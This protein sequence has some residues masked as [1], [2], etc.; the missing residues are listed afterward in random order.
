MKKY[1]SPFFA[2]LFVLFSLNASADFNGPALPSQAGNSG[3]FL[4]TD[5]SLAS[6]AINAGGDVTG[7]ASATSTAIARFNGTTGKII[8]NS[9]ATIDGSGNLTATNFSG[10]STGTNTGD[11]II[12]LTGDVTGSGTGSFAAT[13][14]T[15]NSNVGTF[16]SATKTVTVTATG[17]GLITAISEQTAT[18]AVGSITGLGTGVAT[19]LATPSSANLASA[20]TDETGTGPLVFGTNPALTTATL[21]SSTA[22]TQTPADNS[23]KVA[24][25]AYVDNAVLGQRQ[26]EAVKYAS[27]AALPS[28]VYANGS[29]GVGR[30]LTGVA[31]AAI[32]LDSSSPSV[33]DRV[34]IKDQ[35][36]TFQNGIYT[37]TATGSGIAVFVLTGATDF[38]Q[39]SDIQTGDTTFVTAGS[40]LANTTW[41][42]NGI[43]SPTMGTTAITFAQAAGPGSFTGGNGITITGTSIAINTAVT[44][45]KTTAQ[46][47]TN[48]DLSGAGNTFPTFNQNTTGSAATLTTARTIGGVSFDGS[49][50][51]TVATATGGFTVSGGNL[52]TS[53]I[54]IAT[55]TST[56][57]KFGTATNQKIAFFNSTPI[58]QPTGDVITALQNLGLVAS[59][60]VTA[61]TNANLT[62]PIT[63]V[64]NATSIASQTGTGT[65]FVVDTAPTFTTSITTPVMISGSAD[66][67]DAGAIRLGNA[68]LIEWENNPAGTD[69]TL[70]MDTNN[71]LTSSAPINATT[72]FRI[73]NAAASGK[74]LVGNG[75]NYIASTST[76]PTSAG[77]TANKVLLSDGTNYV[78]S[79]PTFPNAS[80]TSG[81][82]IQSDGT[83]W[84]ASTPT[85]PT[86]SGTAG[87][88]LRSD[89]TNFASSTP[90]FPNTAASAHVLRG[91]GTNWVDA[92]L[93]AADL[94]NGVTGSGAV[95]LANTPTLITPVIG[96][97]TGTS[98]ALTAL[99]TISAT[100][101]AAA[102]PTVQT[103]VLL[104]IGQADSVAAGWQQDTFGATPNIWGERAQGTIASKT[105]VTGNTSLLNINGAGYD[106]TAYSARQVGIQL[107]TGANTWGIADHGTQI[108]FVGT[109]DGSITTGVWA[110]FI[111]SNLK[112]GATTARGTTEGT[113]HL[114]IFNGTAP[115]GTLTNGA[116][117]YSASGALQVM[118]ST[119][120]NTILSS[121]KSAPAISAT[122]TANFTVLSYTPAAAAGQ[123]IVG[124]VITTTSAT[125]TG[126]VQLTVDY[127]D[128]QGTTHTGTILR[129]S[130]SDGT[131][132]TTQTGA[133]SEF[134][135]APATITINNSA[136]AIV[137]KAVITGTVSYTVTGFVQQIF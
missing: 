42:Y 91:D 109:P 22:T 87:K 78:L 72:G 102:L 103:G 130:K 79:T 86:T 18:P 45:D 32:S 48:K 132:N 95:V 38:D 26:K 21:G 83:N 124:G 29:S 36:S 57:T 6:W 94:S 133:S 5:G 39:S 131:T 137:L 96:A 54:N 122:K 11:Q 14:A 129:L 59:A 47:L 135:A 90:T 63:S 52:S 115:A 125:N 123:Y 107:A 114:D 128:S 35:A 61:T 127:V 110:S 68:E 49:A 1:L 69:L 76:I 7:P 4:T 65:K 24:T 40:T 64:G 46:A 105:A 117:I 10:T 80:A 8:Q 112:I 82:F 62:G 88:I 25:T 28:I 97:A 23:T 55:D 85:F 9:G 27:T 100:T 118:D 31:L 73:G 33:N 51:I 119:G 113:A 41:T 66:P 13:L 17:K 30:T 50:N 37:V 75:T 111:N 43:D 19:W 98:V 106:G 16:G 56:G 60:T 53:A 2:L 15:V 136:T 77:A 99:S 3:K 84:I 74:F 89:G 70:G 134:T 92:A 121:I 101:G 44:V 104:Q 58:V 126:T 12:T 93:A 116:S 67:A 20:I 71:V 108:G 120:Q 34:L 81:K